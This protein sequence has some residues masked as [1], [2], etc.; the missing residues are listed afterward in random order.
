MADNSAGA[1]RS[2]PTGWHRIVGRAGR[3]TNLALLLIL[4][5]AL[6]SGIVAFAMGRPV[7][8]TLATAAHGLFGVGV[9]ALLPWKSVIIARAPG[10]RL[11]SL[12]LLILI[13]ICLVAGFVQ[14][15]VGYAHIAG[16][17]PIQV[18]VGAALV[19]IPLLIGHLTRHPRPQV[20]RT[21][22]SRRVL[23]RATALAA[24]VG[25]GYALLAG[26][27]RWSDPARQ[28]VETGSRPLDPDAMPATIWLLDRV[29]LL[30][31]DHRV[32]IVGAAV[33]MSELASG[34]ESV[35]ARLDCTSGW[36]ADATWTGQRLSELIPAAELA[37]AASLRVRSVTGYERSFPASEADFLWLAVA[38]QGRPLTPGTGAPV[39]L[40]APGRRGFW[41]VK[42]V[43]SV[44][45]SPTPSWQQLPFPAQ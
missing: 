12:A 8:A 6:I 14:L 11:A 5:G 13:A 31:A 20:R 43:A 16:V 9:V 40:V 1:R 4:S 42:W 7:G 45:L 38:C 26:V 17:T 29:P 28:R 15:F 19:A 35:V 34:A 18:H 25:A 24:G 23:L 41:W 2:A 32:L 10:L 37:A 27:A 39:R 33:N 3:R 22:L 21:D 44:E 36:Y 30:G